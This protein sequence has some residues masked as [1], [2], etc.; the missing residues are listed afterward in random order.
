MK[1]SRQHCTIVAVVPTALPS[2]Y[3]DLSQNN[4]VICKVPVV[5]DNRTDAF[6]KL[7]LM[8][9]TESKETAHRWALVL[10]LSDELISHIFFYLS[11]IPQNPTLVSLNKAAMF[12][13]S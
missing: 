13:E 2:L 7:I 10:Y 12:N 11:K 3:I 5:T 6:D 9:N 1:T 4:H 8:G